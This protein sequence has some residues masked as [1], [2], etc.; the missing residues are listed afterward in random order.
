MEVAA[1]S[2]RADLMAI[3][4]SMLAAFPRVDHHVGSGSAER[5]AC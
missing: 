1:K 3:E 4:A 5:M 2:D